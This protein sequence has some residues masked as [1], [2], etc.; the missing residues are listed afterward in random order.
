L[1]GNCAA[2]RCKSALLY[3]CRISMESNLWLKVLVQIFNTELM[4]SP[5]LLHSSAHTA[6]IPWHYSLLA[7]FQPPTYKLKHLFIVL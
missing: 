6:L 5:P 7:I 1:E 3:F 2:Q 4:R